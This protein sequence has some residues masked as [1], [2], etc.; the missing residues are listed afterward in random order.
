MGNGVVDGLLGFGE[1]VF[2]LGEP[3]VDGLLGIVDAGV[4]VAA[5]LRVARGLALCLDALGIACHA[6]H[7]VLVLLGEAG[8]LSGAGG[9]QVDD[10]IGLSGSGAR[11]YEEAVLRA[12]GA[13]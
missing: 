13:E 4:G 7:D 2:G 1:F 8:E 12:G 6:V 9:A 10:G 5:N 11:G 3:V